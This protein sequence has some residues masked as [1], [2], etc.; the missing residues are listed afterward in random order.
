MSKIDLQIQ[1]KNALAK[2]ISSKR[3][4]EKQARE[5][6][7]FVISNYES[8]WKD[9][10]SA[11]QPN[12]GKWVRSAYGTEL[13]TL[14]RLIDKRVLAEYDNHLPSFIYGGR[15]GQSNVTAAK[16]LLGY[17]KER[18]LLAVD[19]SKFF[20]NVTAG[21]VNRFYQTVGC[22]ERFSRSLTKLSC[23]HIGPKNKPEST[24][25]LARGF[26]T[27]T[28]LAIW[29]YMNAFYQINDLIHAELDQ[30]DPRIAIFIDDIGVSASRVSEEVLLSLAPKID[31]ILNKESG[32]KLQLNSSKT[33]VM[34]FNSGI[35]HLGVVLTR[36]KLVLPREHQAKKDWYTYRF[37]STKSKRAKAIRDGYRRYEAS[38]RKQNHP[39]L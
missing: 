13:G 15:S 28:R 24:I 2:R 9:N 27:S 4:S 5:L 1:S 22:G 12:K 8:L 31:N 21:K 6:I 33:T 17:E 23:V 35:E 29:S 39:A 34:D 19:I 36:K 32:G 26:S 30:Y 20:E 37:E 3:L 10:L 7:D 11:S 14:L 38:I 16:H 18:S 25:A